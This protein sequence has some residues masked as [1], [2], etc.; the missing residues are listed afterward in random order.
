MWRGSATEGPRPF[1]HHHL[2][3][4]LARRSLERRC[5]ATAGRTTRA[6]RPRRM[7]APPSPRPTCT[8]GPVAGRPRSCGSGP[9]VES[10]HVMHWSAECHADRARSRQSDRCRARRLEHNVDRPSGAGHP[11]DVAATQ[12][13]VRGTLLTNPYASVLF[14]WHDFLS[15]T[16]STRSDNVSV[17]IDAVLFSS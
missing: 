1:R 5:C 15:A 7:K 8:S 3:G 6:R 17:C 16:V 11:A 10:V 14:V 2:A 4:Q 13:C 9:R 12:G